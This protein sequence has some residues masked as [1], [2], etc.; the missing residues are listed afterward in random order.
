MPFTGFVLGLGSC[1]S[2]SITAWPI[3]FLLGHRGPRTHV[4]VSPSYAL[5]SLI[6]VSSLFLFLLF[7]CFQPRYLS[8]MCQHPNITDIPLNA[9]YTWATLACPCMCEPLGQGTKRFKQDSEL[10]HV[11]PSESNVGKNVPTIATTIALPT[12]RT[13]I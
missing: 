13:C 12:E 7:P 1:T 11:L 6:L 5:A 10:M 3:S 8:L 9:E 4:N 2:A